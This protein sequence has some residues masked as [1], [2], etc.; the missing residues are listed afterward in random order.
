MQQES[1][2]GCWA[3]TAKHLQ[4]WAAASQQHGAQSTCAVLGRKSNFFLEPGGSCPGYPA[5]CASSPRGL[6]TGHSF[7]KR[8]LGTSNW[9]LTKCLPHV[10]QYQLACLLSARICSWQLSNYLANV[11]VERLCKVRCG[12]EDASDAWRA[13]PALLLLSLGAAVHGAEHPSSLPM[14]WGH[15]LHNPASVHPKGTSTEGPSTFLWFP[16]A[17]PQPCSGSCCWLQGK[18]SCGTHQKTRVKLLG[19]Q[20]EQLPALISCNFQGKNNSIRHFGGLSAELIAW[21]P[22]RQRD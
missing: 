20:P 5:A 15:H 11:L 16:R 13:N 14:W 4:M 6:I 19:M 7:L 1:A 21:Q 9:H 12:G 18:S 22:G 3:P 8:F 17:P 2:L 10:G